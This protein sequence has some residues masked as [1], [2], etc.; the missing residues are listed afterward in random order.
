MPATTTY[1][2]LLRE[3]RTESINAMGF[4][5]KS[6]GAQWRD[7]RFAKCIGKFFIDVISKV[8]TQCLR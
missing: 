1:A 2:A 6:G 8:R 3:S 4:D 7:L 5:R